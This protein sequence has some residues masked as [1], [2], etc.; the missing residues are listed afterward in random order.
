[1]QINN[2][3][4]LKIGAAIV[5]LYLIIHY[6]DKGISILG[7]GINAAIPLILGCIMAYV[8]N[9]FMVFLEQ[10]VFV[11]CQSKVMIRIKKPLSL[12]LSYVCIFVIGILLFYMVVPELV[13]CIRLLLK[14]L[15]EYIEELWYWADE[16]YN[17]NQW[18]DTNVLNQTQKD[19]TSPDS[20][21]KIAGFIF[22]GVGGVLDVALKVVS[23]TFSMIVTIVVALI[24]SVYILSGKERLKGQFLRL[25]RAYLPKKYEGRVTYV[26]K[27]L[28]QS[29]H[30]FIVGQ[31]I[32]A[33]ILGL[34]C[35]IGM[36]ILRLPYAS[37]VGCLV[38]FTAL[39]PI[40]GAYI[41][42]FVGAFMIFTVS[43]IKA[44]IFI[45][46]LVILQQV[47]GNVIYPRVVGTS[48]GL[49][50]IWVLAAVIIGG[51]ILGIPGMLL[52]VPLTATVYQLLR[53]NVAK[54]ETKEMVNKK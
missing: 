33:V 31:C 10:K 48:I 34:L 14:E 8:L 4:L 18:M 29:F 11:K 15:P 41:G 46:F 24:F 26:L 37:M 44:I 2:K 17:I 25:F 54:K 51:G 16:K 32:E 7:I 23:S 3:N 30:S 9:I 50:G 21:K 36:L 53:G 6:W 22:A 12:I 49:P 40:A 52:G 19:W 1:M 28:H 42:A 38:G 13:S 47:E 27:T 35:M 43:P 39:I 45:I 20:I 5:G